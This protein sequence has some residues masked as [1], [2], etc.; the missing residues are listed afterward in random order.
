MYIAAD[1]Y[2][3][4]PT[5]LRGCSVILLIAFLSQRGTGT[6]PALSS[7][8]KS[9]N[10]PSAAALTTQVVQHCLPLLSFPPPPKANTE[11]PG[12]NHCCEPNYCS[13]RCLV[14]SL[15]SRTSQLLCP[16]QLRLLK[17]GLQS[18]TILLS[19]KEKASCHLAGAEFAQLHLCVSY[20]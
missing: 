4:T 9:L 19:G 2:K 13:R 10:H 17:V 3:Y 1:C 8:T 16:R 18:F 14:A 7:P 5:T 15:Q 20:K 6:S 11:H 12:D